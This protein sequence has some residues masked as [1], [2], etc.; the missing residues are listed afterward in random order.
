MSQDPTPPDQITCIGGN[1]LIFQNNFDRA[2]LQDILETFIRRIGI[3]FKVF[4][5]IH[6]L[7]FVVLVTYVVL[8]L[9]RKHRFTPFQ[10][11]QLAQLFLLICI[12]LPYMY[13]YSGAME[14]GHCGWEQ[15]VYAGCVY[16]I[17]M[18]IGLLFAWQFWILFRQ[19]H[20]YVLHGVLPTEGAKCWSTAIIICTW[21][22]FFTDWIVFI[23]V[24][25]YLLEN[26]LE[27][28][29]FRYQVSQ[30]VLVVLAIAT[31]AMLFGFSMKRI[32]KI[33]G[34]VE[35][36]N[37]QLASYQRLSVFAT[38]GFVCF[39]LCTTAQLLLSGNYGLVSQIL[40]IL[41][42]TFFLAMECIFFWMT[43]TMDLNLTLKTQV[44]HDG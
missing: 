28:A 40:M 9:L 26:D 4:F 39:G 34:F 8:S 37:E 18:S 11:F 19:V 3:T 20:S 10:W 12:Q 27:E 23:F 22:F 33:A 30:S 17:L 41:N 7:F 24:K 32:V 1:G 29:S 36:N 21:L 35:C 14:D 5:A 13:T 16:C 38:V 15:Q 25:H 31:G 6:T 44:L 2:Q 42:C 43:I